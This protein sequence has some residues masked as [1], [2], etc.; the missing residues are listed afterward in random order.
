MRSAPL[1]AA[2][3]LLAG[4]AAASRPLPPRFEAAPDTEDVS[5]LPPSVVAGRALFDM[6]SGDPAREARAR[7]IL[8]ALPD[9]AAID[10]LRSRV[11]TAAPGSAPR[12][13]AL[14]LLAERGDPLAG[15][16]PGEVVS[17][18][19]REI[20]RPEPSA[21]GALLA[22]DRLR[23]MGEAARPAL[24]AE[25]NADGPRSEPAARVLLLLFGERAV[26]SLREA[27]P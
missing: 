23:G 11:L 12:L 26:R 15:V 10:A 17:M 4:C 20:G 3:L 27:R 13:D 7:C 8:L 16:D 22:L 5:G 21:R 6:E 19:L 2:A 25:A 1:W 9:G 24:R 14:A 18:S